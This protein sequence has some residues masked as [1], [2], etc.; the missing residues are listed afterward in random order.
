MNAANEAAIELFISGKC[1]FLD[2]SRKIIKAYEHFD[3]EVQSLDE[4]FELDKEVRAYV[5]N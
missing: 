1:G 4:V 5:G 2:I 3:K